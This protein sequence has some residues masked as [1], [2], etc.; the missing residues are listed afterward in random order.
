MPRKRRGLLE[1]ITP[2]GSFRRAAESI[3]EAKQSV[4]EALASSR[5]KPAR[6][7]DLD[8]RDVRRITDARQRFEVMYQMHGWTEAELREQLRA[9]RAT[10]VTAQALAGVAFV[11]TL[12]AVFLV[13][14][15][16]LMI[17]VPLGGSVTVLCAAQ[18]F[19]YALWETQIVERSFVDAKTFLAM[20][21]F[22][23]RFIG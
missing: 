18:A 14:P 13:Q 16:M 19:R 7:E 2:V 1:W 21:D 9:V 20:P 23:R 12:G 22:W 10:K 15:L 3:A 17:V 8:E 4:K 6:V 5:V 11:A